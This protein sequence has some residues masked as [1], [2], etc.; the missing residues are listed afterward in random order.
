MPPRANFVNSGVVN[1]ARTD[2]LIQ[3][4]FSIRHEMAPSKMHEQMRLS[5]EIQAQNLL[6][7]RAKV[8]FIE[9]P[10][11]SSGGLISPTRPSRFSGDPQI[12][13]NKV[14]PR[15]T[16]PMRSTAPEPLAAPLHRPSGPGH[17]YG[18]AQT[19]QGAR[20]MRIAMRFTF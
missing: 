19:F 14:M 8:A 9:G 5:F 15:T 20:N 10:V 4:D 13:W 7:Q 3:T 1:N 2:P 11:A 12:D 6:N 16:T 18:L 17:P